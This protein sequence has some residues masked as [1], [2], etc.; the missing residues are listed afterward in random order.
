M[1][2]VKRA[3]LAAAAVLATIAVTAC[4]PVAETDSFTSDRPARTN[5][6]TTE[7]TPPPAPKTDPYTTSGT[8]LVPS[9]IAPGTY[10]VTPTDSTGY[11]ATCADLACEI[12]FDG[13]DFTGLIDNKLV[14]GKAAY[15]VIPAH[16]V[17]V[18]LRDVTLTPTQ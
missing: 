2:I 13:S 9:E 17:A 11:V 18:E 16:A 4:E 15:L 14:T 6:V 8:W 1:H 7:W 3:A 12:D 10:K 5:R